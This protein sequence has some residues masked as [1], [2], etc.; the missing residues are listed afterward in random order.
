MSASP[1]WTPPFTWAERVKY[2]LIPPRLYMWR[3]LRKHARKGEAELKLLPAL[4]ARDKIAIDIGANKGVYTHVLAT[5]CRRV[6]AF[7][8]N[9]KIYGVLTRYLPANVTPHHVALSDRAGVAELVIPARSSGGYSNQGASLNPAKKESAPHGFGSVAV[10]ARTLD[11][12]AFTNVGFIKID[13][14]G[15]EDA[16]LRGAAETLKRERP[17]VLL[18]LEERHTGAPIEKSLADLAAMGFDVFFVRDGGLTPIAAFNPESDHRG[19]YKHA[20]YVFNFVLRP[21]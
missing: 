9:P 18:E 12:Y 15:F 4:V 17:T 1:T 3:L 21:R 13:V 6:E 7:E 20:N 8:P 16:V 2:A 14:E 5:L 19:R 10:E 11:S